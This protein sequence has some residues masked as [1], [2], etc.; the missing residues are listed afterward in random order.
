MS[1]GGTKMRPLRNFEAMLLVMGCVL[2]LLYGAWRIDT[3]IISQAAVS[4]FYAQATDSDSLLERTRPKDS[5]VDFAL[6]SKKR[7]QAYEAALFTMSEKPLAVLT[8]PDVGIEV[9]VFEGTDALTLDLGAGRI[10]GTAKLGE[11]GN[12][13][14]A[15]HRDGFFRNLKDIRLGD[16]ILLLTKKISI[17]EVDDIVIVPPTDVSVLRP[18]SHPALTL[19][20]CYPFYFVGDAPQ[21]YVVHASLID[22]RSVRPAVNFIAQGKREEMP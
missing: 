18:R 19:I 12:A 11:F 14:I 21:R 7:I 17:Y 4:S 8:I 6:W 2:L 9:P 15:A 5:H 1:C 3:L 13:G 16:H 10:L 22:D 20:T